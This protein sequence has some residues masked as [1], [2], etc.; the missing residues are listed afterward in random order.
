[1][2]LQAPP[3]TL[4]ARPSITDLMARPARRAQSEGRPSITIPM[5]HP[6]LLRILAEPLFTMALMVLQVRLLLL[7]IR[8]FLIVTR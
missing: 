6:A 8:L 7:V 4:A 2:A 3:L 1:M 5:D